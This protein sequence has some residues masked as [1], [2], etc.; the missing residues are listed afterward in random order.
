MV[1]YGWANIM[2]SKRTVAHRIY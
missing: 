1:I 2:V